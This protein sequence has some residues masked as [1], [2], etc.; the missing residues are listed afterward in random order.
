MPPPELS[1]LLQIRDAVATGSASAVEICRATLAAIEAHDEDV[2][3]FTQRRP[4]AG[5][6]ARG[7]HRRGLRL[8]TAGGRP[9]RAQGQHLHARLADNGLIEGARRLHAAVR[10]HRCG[11]AASRRR[12][13]RRK[14]ELRRVRNG[15]VDRELRAGS[16]AQ[17]LGSRAHAG[18]VERW[19]R[20]RRGRRLRAGCARIRYRRIDPPARGLL[21][22][23]RAQAHLRARVEVR[24]AR[25]C[26]LARSDRSAHAHGPRRCDSD[27]CHQR[28]RSR[29]C[30]G[31]RGACFRLRRSAHRGCQRRPDRCTGAPAGGG[32]RARGVD[33]LQRSTRAA[34]GFGATIQRWTFL[35]RTRPSRS[36]TW[37]RP[38][39][40]ARTWHVT[41]AF[42]TGTAPAAPIHCA[43]CTTALATKGSAPK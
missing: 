15:I 25:V 27:E 33:P 17:P 31:R 34:A 43:R 37:S 18:R 11:V 6:C 22:P 29:R 14:D 2:H 35:T 40:R 26:L 19:I 1:T 21:R 5:A 4:R 30:H 36:T 23:C 42:G 24:P 13:D 32:R 20:R 28:G 9:A 12:R 38:P 41:T 8:R 7:G 39:K 16:V 10:C 3:A